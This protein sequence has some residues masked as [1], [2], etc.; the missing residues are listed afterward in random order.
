MVM[1]VP[2][3]VLGSFERGPAGAVAALAFARPGRHAT[4]LC[5]HPGSRRRALL[6]SRVHRAGPPER[7]PLLPPPPLLLSRAER[8]G[9]ASYLKPRDAPG[10]REGALQAG[11][12][13]E[14]GGAPPAPV[15][16]GTRSRALQVPKSRACGARLHQRR[17]PPSSFSASLPSSGRRRSAGIVSSWGCRSR[18]SCGPA[19]AASVRGS[20]TLIPELLKS[21]TAPYWRAAAVT[22]SKTAAASQESD[23]SSR[24][25]PH[26]P[27]LAPA[28]LPSAPSRPPPLP[29]PPRG[30]L[31][32]CA[33]LRPL[34]EMQFGGSWQVFRA[35]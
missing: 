24:S 9:S 13:A 14:G 29:P 22:F 20:R 17:V 5:L 25:S 3:E 16:A 31:F 1:L 6:P 34:G 4:T 8:L 33:G 26:H 10:D 23:L 12:V 28:S 2:P 19:A 27:R 30:F 32:T 35:C 21:W 11:G 7:L 18:S 15:V